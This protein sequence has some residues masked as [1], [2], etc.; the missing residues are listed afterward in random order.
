MLINVNANDFNL[1]NTLMPSYLSTFGDSFWIYHYI[2]SR[3]KPQ[4]IVSFGGIFSSV[5]ILSLFHFVKR[6]ISL[7]F[8]LFRWYS[9]TRTKFSFYEILGYLHIFRLVV[10]NQTKMNTD[11][12][13]SDTVKRYSVFFC[14]INHNLQKISTNWA[15]YMNILC[16]TQRKIKKKVSDK[17]I[18]EVQTITVNGER[19]KLIFF[20]D[21]LL[22]F[23]HLIQSQTNINPHLYK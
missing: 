5:F 23:D 4:N 16:I 9:T 17:A 15:Y 22:N 3:S 13:Y 14:A 8:Q 20:V 2:I 7:L 18:I 21:T 11:L 1:L 12:Y 6:N 10:T 19:Y